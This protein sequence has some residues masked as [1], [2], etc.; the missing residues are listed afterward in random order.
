M[1]LYQILT[2]LI[3]FV[4]ILY[5]LSH[6]ARRKKTLLETLLWLVFWG[7]IALWAVFPSTFGAVGRFLGFKDYENAIIV[8][9]VGVLCFIVFRIVMK[10]E[11]LDAKITEI[12]RERALDDPSLPVK[13][14]RAS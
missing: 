13:D 8:S 5:A 11:D 7:V 14:E 10:I 6:A 1:N 2:P 12:V 3:A 4:A 9:V